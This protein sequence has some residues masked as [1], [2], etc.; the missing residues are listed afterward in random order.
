MEAEEE[1]GGWRTEEGRPSVEVL[2]ISVLSRRRWCAVSGAELGLVPLPVGGPGTSQERRRKKKPGRGQ[3][4]L[5]LGL[6]P[7]PLGDSTKGTVGRNGRENGE[8]EKKKGPR[9]KVKS[10]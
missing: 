8:N 6:E 4:R 5:G 10:P 3:L 9:T 2:M 1:G 7:G